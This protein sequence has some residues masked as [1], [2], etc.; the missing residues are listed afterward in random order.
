MYVNHYEASKCIIQKKTCTKILTMTPHLHLKKSIMKI[1]SQLMKVSFLTKI[2]EIAEYAINLGMRLPE[3][4]KYLDI[5]KAGLK[6]KL[7]ED[8]QVY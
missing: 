1:M 6:A 5:A 2:V 7:P 4:N 8:W 3:D